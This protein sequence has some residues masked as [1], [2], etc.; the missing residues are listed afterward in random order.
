LI[1]CRRLTKLW[2]MA[3]DLPS[4]SD[5]TLAGLIAR[6]A[7]SARAMGTAHQAMEVLYRRHARPLMAFLVARVFPRADAEDVHQLVWQQLW[8]HLPRS[9]FSGGHFP[10]LLYRIARNEAIDHSRK[11]RPEV[12]D[13]LE[14]V[15]GPSSNPGEG[16]LEEERKE[17]LKRCL[18]KL[19]DQIAALVRARLA[20]EAYSEICQ[21]L[22]VDA[23]RA[24]ALYHRAS[25]QLQTC[26]ER[27][28]S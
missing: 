5:E 15:V 25:R 12:R 18:G 27:E 19:E 14:T 13:D 7:E 1:V 6:C 21:R 17:A 26:V 20:G 4:S 11:H 3:D 22:N 23:R 9:G 16:L 10:A 2:T 8:H 28:L 24:H